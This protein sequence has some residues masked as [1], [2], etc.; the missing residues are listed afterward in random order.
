MNTKHRIALLLLFL[1]LLPFQADAMTWERTDSIAGG[2][3]IDWQYTMDDLVVTATR[4]PKFLKDS[5]IQIRV[6]NAADIERADA[7]NIMDLLQQE[8]PGVEFSY[9]M[10]QQTHLNFAGFGGQSIL[11]L[12]DGERLAGE[13]MD[14]VDFSRL[15]MLNVERIEIIRGAASALYGSNAAGGVINIITKK[16]TQ[17][18]SLDANTRFAKH[19][20]QRYGLSLGNKGK[21]WRNTFSASYNS[22]D[23]Y[24]V[25]SDDDPVTRIISTI[26]GEKVVN[27]KEQ[28]S[29][30]ITP[31]LE[32]GARAGFFFR[33]VTK[34]ADLPE[35]YR[36]FSG[37]VNAN[38]KITPSDV[39]QGSYSFDQYDKSDYQ[40]IT[41]LDIRDYSNVQ[42]TFRLLYYHT[43]KEGSVVT[44]GSDYT[45]DFL[46]NTNMVGGKHHQ[47]C[48]DVFAQFDWCINSKWEAVAAMRY[49]WFSENS[50]SRMTPKVNLRYRPLDNLSLRL[51]YGMGFRAPSLKEK[52]YNFD[53][54]GIWMVEGNPDL[55][56]EVSHNINV[57][58][59]YTTHGY[60]LNLSAYYNNVNNKISTSAPYF[61]STDDRLPYMPYCNLAKY[62]VYGMEVGVQKKWSMGWMVKFLYAYTKE[63][64]PKNKEG[65]T[66][67]NQYIPARNHSLNVTVGYEKQ[68]TKHYGLSVSLNGRVL[69]GVENMEYVNYYDISQGM[70]TIQ[71]PA[72]TIWKLST[73]QCLGKYVKLNLAL[74]NILNYRPRYYYLNSPLTDGINF[75]AG[76]CV[77]L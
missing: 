40:R 60:N 67:N 33:Q 39:L 5:P 14:D 70:V 52:Y 48:F 62:Q 69:S 4:T 23:N 63:R 59:E 75:Q 34:T 3:S 53:M 71:Y 26:Y 56:P 19:G 76:L 68:F 1:A 42:N 11:F 47:D 7:T 37:G 8:L 55:L 74:D 73:T 77:S 35:R 44:A 30:N 46:M 9:A 38:W 50:I 10:N 6:L 57:S 21:K 32:V 18:W 28:F 43:F 24:D 27:T 41:H 64:L 45:H 54:S 29:W 15:S 51:G 36:D 61:K 49:D 31:E 25:K 12:V 13:T 16:A 20:E 66:V 65:E 17:P 58:A 22:K 72:Y 2:D